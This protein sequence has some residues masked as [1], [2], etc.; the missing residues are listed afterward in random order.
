MIDLLRQ[1]PLLLLFLVAAVSYPLGLVRIGGSN[2]GIAAVLFVGLAFGA[3]DPDLKLP[4]IVYQ[5]GLILFVYAV[6]LSSGPGFFQALK[7]KGLRDSLFIGGMVL[8]AAALTLGVKA[9]LGLQPTHTAGLFAGS[10]TNTPALAGILEYVKLTSPAATRDQLLTE[11]V[12]GYSIAYPVGVIGMLLAIIL[13]QRWWKPNYPA[14]AHQ[15]RD[16]GASAEA[17]VDSTIRVTR[18][19]IA[20][21][22]LNDLIGKHAWRVIFAR[23][24]R[25]NELALVDGGTRLAVGDLVS[26]T[27]TVEDIQ[28]VTDCL[29]TRSD[30]QLSLD[31]STFDIRRIFVSNPEVACGGS[32]T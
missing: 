28:Q 12:V 32:A 26:L 11:P 3:L 6:G 22:T 19:E 4:E 27:G 24:K 30:E 2:L 9:T 31:R 18:P 17:F 1:Q 7:R 23:R 8:L 16:L 10:M 14:E 25:G 29:G 5:L 13:T 21:Q 20:G 15:L